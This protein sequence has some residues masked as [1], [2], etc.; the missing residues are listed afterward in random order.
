MGRVYKAGGWIG[1]SMSEGMVVRWSW[2][3]VVLDEWVEDFRWSVSGLWWIGN[4]GIDR[5]VTDGD[6]GCVR[7]L[8]RAVGGSGGGLR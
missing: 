5:V 1:R 2:W 8:G 7:Q 3:R 6:G 4:G